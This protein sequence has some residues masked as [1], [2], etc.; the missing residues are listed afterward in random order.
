MEHLWRIHFRLLPLFILKGKPRQFISV[1]VLGRVLILYLV[2]KN[3]QKHCIALES[4]SGHSR[5][6]LLWVKN[7]SEGLV[8]CKECELP[9]KKVHMEPFHSPYNGQCLFVNLGVPAFRL[10]QRAGCESYWPFAA[11]QHDVWKNCTD[12]GRR[13]I[14]FELSV[15]RMSLINVCL[16]NDC[17][18]LIS[19]LWW[20]LLSAM[21]LRGISVCDICLGDNSV[22]DAHVRDSCVEDVCVRNALCPS[23]GCF[24]IRCHCLRWLCA[25][26]LCCGCI[27]GVSV[28]YVCV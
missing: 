9:P 13:S 15:S 23:A 17:V 4:R 28:L 24:T 1:A 26:C 12:T 19:F 25:R 27:L 20:D 22:L 2:V 3:C 11:I 14:K 21:P 10:G 16:R 7:R 5:N 18:A 6:S 8:V